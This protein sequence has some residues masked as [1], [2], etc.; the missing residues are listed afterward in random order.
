MTQTFK[1][2]NDLFTKA[3]NIKLH[4]NAKE[5]SDKTGCLVTG[6]IAP[7]ERSQYSVA[8]SL[9]KKPYTAKP[10]AVKMIAPATALVAA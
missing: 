3:H 1:G 6:A 9:S 2:F 4:L 10:G 7:W 8:S 5:S